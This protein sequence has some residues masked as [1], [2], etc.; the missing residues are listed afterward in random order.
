MEKWLEAVDFGL[1]I[2]FIPLFIIITFIVT[3][4]SA[5]KSG[6]ERLDSYINESKTQENLLN[7]EKSNSLDAFDTYTVKLVDYE[8][9]KEFIEIELRGYKD[10][11]LLDNCYMM[12][13]D[14]DSLLYNCI[15]SPVFMAFGTEEDSKLLVY[16]CKPEG[17]DENSMIE[18]SMFESGAVNLKFEN[19]KLDWESMKIKC[20]ATDIFKLTSIKDSTGTVIGLVA[21]STNG[22]EITRY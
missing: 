7:I 20:P 9:T 13:S 10:W 3:G 12:K 17:T 1:V 4:C 21:I 8:N 15:G 14:I 2:L 16:G 19:T 18:K 6:T 22:N 5:Y 11:E